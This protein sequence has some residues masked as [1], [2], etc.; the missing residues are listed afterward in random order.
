[1]RIEAMINHRHIGDLFLNCDIVLAH[2]PI[3]TAARA[4]PYQ[5][6]YGLYPN[7]NGPRKLDHETAKFKVRYYNHEKDERL[8]QQLHIRIQS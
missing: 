4:D 8:T 7:Y 2:D 5:S 6:N 3:V 1:M